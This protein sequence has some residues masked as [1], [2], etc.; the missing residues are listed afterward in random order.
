MGVHN[1]SKRIRDSDDTPDEIAFD[2]RFKKRRIGVDF[3]VIAHKSVGTEDGAG[4]MAMCPEVPNTAMVDR[5]RKLCGWAKQNSIT[6][7]V[8]VDGLYHSLKASVNDKRKN[9]RTTALSE[10]AALVTKFK[11]RQMPNAKIKEAKSLLKKAAHVS[12]KIVAVGVK[13]FRDHGHEVQ[14]ERFLT[15]RI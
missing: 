9:D 11:G 2:Q 3:M 5:C 1:L 4:E 13:V 14:I 15:V 8:S 6:W 7:V 12:D 10:F